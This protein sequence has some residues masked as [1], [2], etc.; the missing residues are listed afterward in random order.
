MSR[1]ITIGRL[2]STYLQDRNGVV[3]RLDRIQTSIDHLEPVFGNMKLSELTRSA[4]QGYTA[5]RVKTGVQPQTAR[6]ELVTLRAA[7]R[8]AW[9][10]GVIDRVPPIPMPSKGRCRERVLSAQEIRAVLAATAV[11]PRCHAFLRLLIATCGR[12]AAVCE[13][14]WAQVDL[15]RRTIDLRS[16]SPMAPRM[17]G[18]AVVPITAELVTFLRAY[19]NA[20]DLQTGRGRRAAPG[21]RVVGLAVTTVRQHLAE[22]A[23]IAG[24][25]GVTPHVIRHS[26]ATQMLRAGVPLAMV[27]KM[28]G[29]ASV[30]ITADV[31]GHL[32]TQDLMPAA[33]IL[34]AWA[35]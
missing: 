7:L 22:A 29:H 19:R 15:E 4:V 27:S 17:K 31:Y 1:R 2:L 28:L 14:T 32:D 34:D 10:D 33:S 13:L 25:A 26:V 16:S 8:L 18:R 23:A 6:R 11:R 24:V 12:A 35:R 5:A 3:V 30:A 20:P 9:R 21:Q